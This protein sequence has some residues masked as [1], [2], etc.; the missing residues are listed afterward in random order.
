MTDQE[1]KT[2]YTA[3]IIA[4]RE[5][6]KR[7]MKIHIARAYQAGKRNQMNQVA[8]FS[9]AELKN[10]IDKQGAV[11]WNELSYQ[12]RMEVWQNMERNRINSAQINF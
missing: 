6:M 8:G 12:Q 5:E 4:G 11:S 3:G 1:R 9:T 10:E 7:E 2:L